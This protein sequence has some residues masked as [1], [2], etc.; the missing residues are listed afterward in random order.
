MAV[1]RTR[2]GYQLWWYDVEGRFRKQTF[3]GIGRDEAV[4]LE[5]EILAAR[6][7]GERPPD[8]RHAPNFEA[9][10]TTWID[11]GRAGWKQSTLAQ[12]QQ[13]LKSQL[14]PVFGALRV[15]AITD[16]RI[17]Q[18]ITSLHDAGLS[19]RRIN[20]ALLVLKMI[21][22]TAVRRR[23][24]REDPT[25]TVRSLREPKT[26]VDPLD[27]EEVTAFLAVCPAWWRP[28]FTVAFW[29]GARPNE[30]AAL[31]W[32][33]VDG[34][35]GIVRIRAGR[36]RG[37]EGP[38]KTASSV[39]DIDLLPPVVDALKAQKAQQAAERLKAGRGAP[40]PGQDY[41]FT[42][43]EGGLLNVNALRDRIWYP[44]LT[45]AALRR[46]IMYQTRHTFASNALAAGDAPSW[47]A[48]TLGHASPEMLFS[49]YARY[50]PNRT[51][52]DG[53]ALLRRIT[54]QKDAETAE[55]AGAAVLPKYS[56]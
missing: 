54:E 34:S 35:R 45:K 28:Y 21:V 2:T 51:R 32:G 19:A 46:R 29:T 6:D 26:E 30:L 27:P 10:A 8:E 22:R 33:D 52:R 41:V 56:R 13:V 5:R 40:E 17:R 14:G 18:L 25:E 55:L 53:S 1:K 3:R 50:I 44:T 36:Y 38:P 23:Y 20:L 48:A 43:P 31:R 47:V 15:S 24:L 39:R 11:E 4:R 42:G 49:V 9:F 7:R 37:K 16:S 12:Y